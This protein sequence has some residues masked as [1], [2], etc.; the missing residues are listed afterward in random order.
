[1][2][3]LFSSGD[4]ETAGT[5]GW[6]F[7]S[8]DGSGTVTKDSSSPHGGTQCLRVTR[9]AT[10]ISAYYPIGLVPGRRYKV[11]A[12]AR[13]DGTALPVIH[14]NTS[15]YV[16]LARFGNAD[17]PDLTKSTT[18]QYF[19]ATFVADDARGLGWGNWTVVDGTWVEFDDATVEQISNYPNL[20]VDG[21]MDVGPKVTGDV[22]TGNWTN[23]L[24]VGTPTVS[25]QTVS[26]GR[27]GSSARVMRI[28]RNGTNDPSIGCPILT[29]SVRYLVTGWGRGD[30]SAVPKVLL[31]TTVVWT[32]TSST[33]WQYFEA[34]VY[35]QSTAFVLQ[36]ITS[37]GTQYVEFDDLSVTQVDDAA[38]SP[39]TNLLTDGD[40]E[41]AD[42]AAW[43][44]S[45]AGT[46][47][48]QTDSPHGGSRYVKFDTANAFITQ[49]LNLTPTTQR[50]RVTGWARGNGTTTGATVNYTYSGQAFWY[51]TWS[52]TWQYADVLFVPDWEGACIFRQLYNAG[53]AGWDDMSIAVDLT[54]DQSNLLPD[55]DC[56]AGGS[57]NNAA[58]VSGTTSSGKGSWP[59]VF[60]VGAPTVTKQAGTRT[61]GSGS[62]VLRV[63][64]NATANPS[65]ATPVLFPGRRYRVS[66]WARGDGSGSYPKVFLGGTLAWTGTTSNTWQSFS[67]T[68]F[69]ASGEFTLQS[70]GSSGY[71][72]YDDLDLR[73]VASPGALYSR[74]NRRR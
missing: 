68:A 28:A 73:Q 63:A 62:T 25:K 3:N 52:A 64:Y 29:T 19:S 16:N 46:A 74:M 55:G 6:T 1:M 39:P 31:G 67:E 37:T 14:T 42:M 32:G 20:L 33:S 12:W 7:Y 41:A 21:D 60:R 11:T 24:R 56:E 26:D 61:G 44:V 51:S 66:G 18:W 43:T 40:A 48:K 72:E 69:A 2:I 49:T 17:T 58:A 50:Y 38:A 23:A 47:T 4:M 45:P 5:T 10:S 57:L 27:A 36:A 13:G 71:T 35:A 15:G 53:T 8:A 9:G 54:R 65:I 30:G 22:S 70:Y 59:N 34:Y